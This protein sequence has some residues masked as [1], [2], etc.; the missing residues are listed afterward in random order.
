MRIDLDREPLSISVVE[1]DNGKISFSDVPDRLIPALVQAY[2]HE[3][4]AKSISPS[5]PEQELW[6]SLPVMKKGPFPR[7][8]TMLANGALEQRVKALGERADGRATY[9]MAAI[10]L[11]DEPVLGKTGVIYFVCRKGCH[12]CQYRDF[13]EHAI[14]AEGIADRM[15]ALQQGG[16]DN[17][18]LLSPTSYTPILVKAIF[19]A[20]QRGLTLPIVHKSEGEDPIADLSLLDGLI[21]M[22][23]PDIKFARPEFAPKIGLSER[24]PERMQACIREMYRQVGPLHRRAEGSLLH[25]SGVLIRHLLMPGGVSELRAVLE[26]VKTIDDEIPIHVMTGYEPLHQ[27]KDVV[28]IDRPVTP[29]EVFAATKASEQMEMGFVLVR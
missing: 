26:L 2:G 13:D 12:F 10:N 24:Y 21:D 19:L 5:Q 11:S 29:G 27:A 3:K 7:F 9:F 14:G 20:A 23:L 25:G 8:K 15:L 1:H 22:Y 6:M 28:G 18:Q 4:V 16:A 17:I